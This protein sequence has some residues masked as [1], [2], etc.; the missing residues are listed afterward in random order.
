M[1]FQTEER[2]EAAAERKRANWAY[3]RSRIKAY[4]WL[5]MLPFLLLLWG[6]GYGKGLIDGA[7]HCLPGG[8]SPETISKENQR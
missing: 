7:A 4:F 1:S 3:V 5:L 2:L 8:R 6:A